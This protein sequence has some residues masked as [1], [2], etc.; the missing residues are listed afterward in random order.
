LKDSFS[1]HADLS[2]GSSTY[3]IAALK[4]LRKQGFDLDR[5]P[6][7]LKILL[8]NMLRRE[9]GEVV[10]KGDIEALLNWDPQAQPSQEIAFMPARVL[11][12]DFTGVPAIVDLA[13]MRDAMRDMDSDPE[14]INPVQPAELVIDHSVQVDE[15]GRQ[16]AFLI[17]A[18][19]EF[20]RNRERYA[21]LKW[22]QSAFQN[23]KVVPP[24]T[25]I[26]HQVNLEYL[27]R[28]VMDGTGSDWAYPDTLVGTDSHTTM[29]NGLGVLGWGVG[30]IEAEAAML[31]QPI[32][33]LIP[34]VVGFRLVGALAEG[35]TATDLVL[36]VTQMLRERGVVSKFVEYFGP[37]LPSLPLADRAT[38]ANMSPEYG[39][40]CGIFPVDEVS[41][42]YLRFTGRSEQRVALVEA[43]MKEQGLFHDAS[44]PEATYSD[45]LELDLSTVQPSL[46]GPK[47]PQDR[48]L[49]GD[50]KSTFEAQLDGLRGAA[51]PKPSS[52]GRWESEGGD[53]NTHA[54][55][56][57]EAPA[58]TRVTESGVET[59]LKGERFTV[60]DG[61]I[62][63]AAITS[64]TNTSNPSVMLAAGLLAK[65][66]VERGLKS[67]PWVK[68]SLAPGSKVVT[69]YLNESKLMPHL[70]A[71]GF[72]LVG[73]GCTTCIGNSGPLPEPIHDA[74]EAGGLVAASIL[75]GN[76]NFEGRIS[77]D[78]RA[79][80]L[81][82][83][84]LVVAYALAGRINID[85]YDEP[86]GTDKDGEPVYLRDIWPSN[87]EIAE[88]VHAFVHSEMFEREYASVFD[89]DERWNGLPV[90]QGETYAWD[91]DS[92]YVR[93]PPF[94]ENLP[95]EA[96]AVE[97]IAGARALA[98]VGDS[99]TT[100][101]ISPAGAIKTDS[102]AG[103]Y[104][105]EH[106]VAPKDFN[107]YGSR[108]GNHEVMMRGTFANV[109]L[110]NRL[111]PEIE[112]GYTLHMPSGESMSIY[113]AAMRYQEEDVPTIILAGKEYGTGSSRDWA[114]KGPALLGVRAVV[115]ASYERIHRSNLIGMGVAP[116]EFANGQSAESLG[117]TGHEVFAVEGLA[118]A[119]NGTFRK[120][121]EVT[122]VATPE[123]GEPIRFQAKVRLDTPQ[124]VEYYRHGGIL[125]YVLRQ[126]LAT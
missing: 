124:E 93:L 84:P 43:Y 116:L 103:K 97:D 36:T 30:G 78:V 46:A 59:E 47:R 34:Q 1:T 99:V 63:I 55:A 15:Y 62:V 58:T 61:S 39:A 25:G 122:V 104:L 113:D 85:L 53:G 120:G 80:F 81:A 45:T 92:T 38:I 10:D 83:P 7:S 90:P 125:Q 64:C 88:A 106:G 8:E 31:G 94:F 4:P 19:K 102:P 41:L 114:A 21:F 14:Q 65:K 56:V 101:H 111:V 67:K 123:E 89:G 37:G 96:P 57:A 70:E 98:V 32:S 23:F 66:A 6:Y 109:R 86:L 29:I 119:L 24:D 9:D 77:P 48:I 35:A 17:N 13:A 126:L 76:R 18:E 75:S 112:G 26:V 107:S 54:V 118:A 27:A 79:N 44:A 100:D 71:L 20:E 51:K 110:R 12:Q 69:D 2:V 50:V 49:L 121:A 105:Q 95:R 42:E 33:M 60:A 73:Y 87:Q 52:V 68:T 91:P 11:L 16:A 117:L 72:H 115:A 82:S 22:G 40:T 3:R 74:V 28:V 5:L 108:R